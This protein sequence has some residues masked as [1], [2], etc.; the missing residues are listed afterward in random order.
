MM[1]SRLFDHAQSVYWNG[2]I[3]REYGDAPSAERAFAEYANLAKK[4]SAKDPDNPDWLA[5]VGYAHSNL[6]VLLLEQGRAAEAIAQ[7]RQSLRINRKRATLPGDA[8]SRSSWTSDRIVPGCHRPC[9]R[10]ASCAEAI[11]ERE[12]ELDIYASAR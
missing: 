9:M 7:F 6:G 4:L 1:P 5:E 2:Y 12:A 10:T 11:T 8:K 3:D